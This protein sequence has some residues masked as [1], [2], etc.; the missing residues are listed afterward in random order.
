MAAAIN[1]GSSARK[2]GGRFRIHVPLA[3]LDKKEII[4]LGFELG[5]DYAHS[6]SCY[7]GDE[8]P[9]GRCPSCDIRARAFAALGRTDPLLERLRREGRA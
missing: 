1:E 4:A 3:R 5:V 7:R 8:V 9:C 6:V 2:G